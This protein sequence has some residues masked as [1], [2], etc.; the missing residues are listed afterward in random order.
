MI[1]HSHAASMPFGAFLM[2]I[3]FL[4]WV[5]FN[6]VITFFKGFKKGTKFKEVVKENY[7]WMG[8]FVV[9]AAFLLNEIIR[10]LLK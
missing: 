10:Y 4:L 7:L 3:F 9:L 5:F 2:D 1:I 8:S 6:F